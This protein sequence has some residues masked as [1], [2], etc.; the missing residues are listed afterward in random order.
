[1]LLFGHIGITAGVVKACDALVSMSRPDNSYEPDSS[2]RF[3]IVIRKQR[4]RLHPLLSWI[5]D[6]LGSIDYR[7]VL[8][9]S[10]LPDFIDKPLWLFAIG[11]IAPSG[12]GYAHTLLFNLT[13]FICG[14]ILFR[15]RKSWLLIISLY[16]F[17]HLIFDQIWDSPVVLLWPLLGPLPVKETV[18][19][20]FNIIQA[21]FSQ[22]SVYIP[23]IIGL[24]IILLF[25][26]RL[27]IRRSFISFIRG[28]AV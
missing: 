10:L 26:Y 6:R 11:Y 16:S 9:G 1:M 12:R 18:G 13:L 22:P 7:I 25:A 17:M 8:L 20:L 15:Y 14:L 2:S 19:W 23:E 5:K 27:M 24:V 3:G 28:G 4:L 21:L